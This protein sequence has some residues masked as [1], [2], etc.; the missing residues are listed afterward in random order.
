[1]KARRWQAGVWSE[2]DE[3][4]GREAPLQILLNQQ[5]FAVTM[6][7]PGEDEDLVRGLLHTEGVATMI[8]GLGQ[9]TL[10]DG[11]TAHVELPDVYICKELLER[12]TLA[13]NSSC[14]LCGQRTFTPI[15]G[16]P[17]PLRSSQFATSAVPSL[18]VA[19]RSS[20]PQFAATGG[21]HAAAAVIGERIAFL[22]ED[23]GRHNA[24][25]K[26]V[27]QALRTGQGIDAVLV[28][29]RVSYEIVTK[30]YRL[31]VSLL[32]AVSAPT[33]L[34]IETAARLGI[35]VIGFCRDDRATV[36]SHPENV[37]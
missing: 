17:L 21:V 18:L 20:Q 9:I 4:L 19:L 10:P 25:D 29:G 1:M 16:E 5:S 8:D 28:S 11:H 23:V 36:Y 13:I 15:E 35:T 27:G 37:R 12:R 2:S 24:V 7:T 30:V 26:I 6:R 32:L 34:A 22:A 31:G 3:Q 14:G 33:T